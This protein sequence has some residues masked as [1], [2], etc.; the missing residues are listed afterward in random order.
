MLRMSGYNPLLSTARLGKAANTTVT[1]RM[2]NT[3]GTASVHSS[4]YE[5]TATD[6]PERHP[7]STTTVHEK[8][9]PITCQPW[10]KYGDGH[11]NEISRLDQ[12]CYSEEQVVP[13]PTYYQSVESWGGVYVQ[14]TVAIY[15]EQQSSTPGPPLV[16][17]S[18][19]GAAEMLRMSLSEARSIAAE[20]IAAADLAEGGAR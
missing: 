20:I 9:S 3:T 11:P 7:M 2:R 14:Q 15:V 4:P 8:V 18:L 5:H 13:L 12:T 10:C 19:D 17:I 6:Q 1:G 16:E